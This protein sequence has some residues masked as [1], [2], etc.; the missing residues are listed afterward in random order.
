MHRPGGEGASG[1]RRGGAPLSTAPAARRIP[2]PPAP[3]RSAPRFPVSTS[4]ASNPRSSDPSS[5]RLGSPDLQRSPSSR[6][7]GL[8]SGITPE[9]RT[10]GGQRRGINWLPVSITV[11][12][13]P[14][15]GT[16]WYPGLA[17]DPTPNIDSQVSSR[18]A[19]DPLVAQCWIFPR[20]PTPK[21]GETD[22]PAL[23]SG[24][25]FPG[26]PE[27]GDPESPPLPRLTLSNFSPGASAE[28]KLAAT[29]GHRL[30]YPSQAGDT[31]LMAGPDPP[32]PRRNL[33]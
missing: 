3:P 22:L 32:R 24:C 23:K 33:P 8:L 16:Q 28:Q 4:W 19:R 18:V 20:A 29:A 17:P 5:R 27:R 30:L 7:P 2:S 1:A 14:R 11:H 25:P 31:G 26:D 6:P 15:L 10:S 12:S 21:S 13:H 9:A